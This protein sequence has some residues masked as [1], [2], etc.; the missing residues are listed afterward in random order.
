[1]QCGSVS[2]CKRGREGKITVGFSGGD[3]FSSVA[4]WQETI[5]KTGKLDHLK[6]NFFLG[7]FCVSA[8][9]ARQH[10]FL[11]P[12]TL[13]FFFFFADID[14][15]IDRYKYNYRLC[16]LVVSAEQMDTHLSGKVQKS[17]QGQGLGQT[18]G[19][20]FQESK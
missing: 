15:D 1:M 19:P 13:F 11:S 2:T 12:G 16:Y 9:L 17:G 4:L 10:L 8:G 3:C 18:Q 5:L 6:R 14:A 20:Q 7:C